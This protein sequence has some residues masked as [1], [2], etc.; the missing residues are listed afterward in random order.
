MEEL[1]GENALKHMEARKTIALD[2]LISAFRNEEGSLTYSVLEA[3]NLLGSQMVSLPA[4]GPILFRNATWQAVRRHLNVLD[5]LLSKGLNMVTLWSEDAFETMSSDKLMKYF[6]DLVEIG[7]LEDVISIQRAFPVGKVTY[8]GGRYRDEEDPDFASAVAGL[9][10][11]IDRNWNTWQRQAISPYSAEL[12]KRWDLSFQEFYGFSLEELDLVNAFFAEQTK[13][14]RDELKTIELHVPQGSTANQLVLSLI[15]SSLPGHAMRQAT[16]IWPEE[17]LLKGLSRILGS[18]DKARVWLKWLVYEPSTRDFFT[19]PLIRVMSLEGAVGYAPLFWLFHPA[20]FVMEMWFGKLLKE[21]PKSKAAKRQSQVYGKLF[22]DYVRDQF[23][24]AGVPRENIHSNKVIRASEWG[25]DI[26]PFL[27]RLKKKG[28]RA[29]GERAEDAHHQ[30]REGF[31]VDHIVD[32]DEVALAVSCK[33][34]DFGFDYRYA[35]SGFFM[36]YDKVREVIDQDLEYASEIE[37]EADCLNRVDKLKKYLAIE[38]KPVRPVLVT[39]RQSPIHS[40][41]VRNYLRKGKPVPDTAVV[42]IG[43]LPAMLSYLKLNPN[44]SFWPS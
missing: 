21:Q 1:L 30:R 40:V 28:Q 9:D 20:P 25:A 29:A 6:T 17:D 37:T 3:A 14:H 35:Q 38:D 42:S 41:G 12:E 15:H 26:E 10:F 44:G 2:S 27:D 39:S 33:A 22:E 31:E 23:I 19:R 4:D 43:D 32:L 34:S 5:T 7:Y 16:L 13:T 8:E 36:A 24:A 18:S 11:S